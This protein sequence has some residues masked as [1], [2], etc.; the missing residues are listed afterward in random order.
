VKWRDR[1]NLHDS[2]FGSDSVLFSDDYIFHFAGNPEP[3]KEFEGLPPSGKQ[4]EYAGLWIFRISEGKIVESWGVE[5][6]LSFWMQLCMELKPKE[7]E[8]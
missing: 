5:D 7:G 1:K 4:V 6:F 2:T 8:K 3:N